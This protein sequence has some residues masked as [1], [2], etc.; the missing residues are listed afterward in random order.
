MKAA[1]FLLSLCLVSGCYFQE[2][3]YK[4]TPYPDPMYK[5]PRSTYNLEIP[6]TT[7]ESCPYSH[8]C[9]REKGT[10][11]QL[12]I[13]QPALHPTGDNPM[14]PAFVVMQHSLQGNFIRCP[15]NNASCIY[16]AEQQ[17][18]V[19]SHELPYMANQGTPQGYPGGRWQYQ[20]SVPRW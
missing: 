15:I 8:T 16:Q 17:G 19:K 10:M 20:E 11:E 4:E 5:N 14:E 1:V 12:P 6:Y 13:Y 3:R 18:Y 2:R 9:Y 7:T